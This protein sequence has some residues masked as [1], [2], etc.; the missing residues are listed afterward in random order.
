MLGIYCKTGGFYYGTVVILWHSYII[1]WHSYIILF[2]EKNIILHRAQLT[3]FFYVSL[4]KVILSLLQTNV[5][6]YKIFELLNCTIYTSSEMW[7]LTLLKNGHA[8]Y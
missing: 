8:S 3:F 6:I 7:C 1:L 4:N 5:S 2:Y